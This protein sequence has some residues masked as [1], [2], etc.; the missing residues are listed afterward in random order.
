MVE[1]SKPIVVITGVSGYLGS[2]VALVFLKDGSYNVRGTVRD[3][4]NPTKID[5]LRKAFGD[6]FN[7]LTLVEAD[8]NNEESIFAALQGAHFV[9]HTASPFPLAPPRNETDLINP[10]V[11]GTVSVMKACH[12]NKV[13]RI[14]ITSSIAAIQAC[15]AEDRPLDGKFSEKNWS[16]PVG[17]H[18]DAYSKSKTLAEQ[19]AWD[20]QKNLPEHER[21]EIAT[22]NPGLIMGPAFVGAGFSSGEIISK[23][24]EGEYPGVP[25]VMISLVDVRE[26]AEAHL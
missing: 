11:N 24:M 7:N 12:A 3:A 4:K 9:V 21:F 10:A 26:V 22:I 14:V 2:H 19:A 20:F 16:N 15:K 17:D 23:F 18:I 8:L 5:P 6:L 13:K 25:K 1:S